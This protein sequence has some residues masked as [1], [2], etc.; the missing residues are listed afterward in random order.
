[1]GTNNFS[2]YIV[3]R[4]HSDR[5]HVDQWQFVKRCTASPI[6]HDVKLWTWDIKEARLFSYAV[7]R[8]VALRVPYGMGRIESVRVVR[9]L[10]SNPAKP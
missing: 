1:M 5:D 3:K 9:S 2:K 10:S 7:A 4:L 6:R 8:A